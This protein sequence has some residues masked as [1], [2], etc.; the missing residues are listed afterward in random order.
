M[1][2]GRADFEFGVIIMVAMYFLRF[3]DSFDKRKKYKDSEIDEKQ[4]CLLLPK[5]RGL[6]IWTTHRGFYSGTG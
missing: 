6:P 1:G 3:K 4:N 5:K 2:K